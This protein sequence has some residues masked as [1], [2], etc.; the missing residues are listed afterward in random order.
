MNYG[1]ILSNGVGSRFG[2]DLPKQFNIVAGSTVISYSIEALLKSKSV[3]KILIVTD[4][5]Y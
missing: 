3:Y 4:E 5:Q 2:T 1:V